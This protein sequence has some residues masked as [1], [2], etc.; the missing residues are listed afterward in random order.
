MCI[1]S[2]ILGDLANSLHIKNQDAISLETILVYI[3]LVVDA[4]SL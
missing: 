1:S 3:N 4:T 2:F